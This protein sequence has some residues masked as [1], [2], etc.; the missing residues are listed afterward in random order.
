MRVSK[1]CAR[2]CCVCVGLFE[3]PD[4]EREL[5]EDEIAGTGPEGRVEVDEE[6]EL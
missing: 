2:C 1:M 5:L 4:A 6:E 3:A